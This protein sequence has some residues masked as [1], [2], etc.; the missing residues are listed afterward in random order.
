MDYKDIHI[1][2]RVRIRSWEDM[3]Q[4]FETKTTYWGEYIPT[5]F[6]FTQGM[7]RLCGQE[8]TVSDIRKNTNDIFIVHFYEEHQGGII[9][10]DML[11][12]AEPIEVSTDEPPYEYVDISSFLGR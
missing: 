1:G 3:A 9:T 5:G 2:D 11:E 10:Q 12:P 6:P 4:E 7:R 8:F